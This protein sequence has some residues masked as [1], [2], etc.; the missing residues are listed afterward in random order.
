[1]IFKPFYRFE[2]GCAA[3]LFGCG[4]QGIACVVD[5][6]EA[7]VDAYREFATSKGMRIMRFNQGRRV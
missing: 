6:Q 7:D 1:M 2:I 3:Y 4:G 5:P